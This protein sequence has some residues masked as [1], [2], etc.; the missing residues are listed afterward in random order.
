MINKHLPLF[1][2][3]ATLA[4]TGAAAQGFGPAPSGGTV[5]GPVPDASVVVVLLAAVAVLWRVVAARRAA[6]AVVV[7]AVAFFAGDVGA[8]AA[9]A[10]GLVALTTT[11]RHAAVAAVGVGALAAGMSDAVVDVVAAFDLRAAYALLGAGGITAFVDGMSLQLPHG[12]LFIAPACAAVEGTAVAFVIGAAVQT[13]LGASPRRVLALASAHAAVFAA[14]NVVRIAAIGVALTSSFA[15]AELVHALGAL[16]MIAVHVP[17]LL[18]PLAQLARRATV[19]TIAV[20]SLSSTRVAGVAAAAFVVAMPAAAAKPKEK[21]A[22][23]VFPIAGVKADDVD[24]QVVNEYVVQRGERAGFKLVLRGAPSSSNNKGAAIAALKKARAGRA[25]S[26]TLKNTGSAEE[27]RYVLETFIVSAGGK[28]IGS[29]RAE[30]SSAED[31]GAVNTAVDR[32][33]T[34]A[35]AVVDEPAVVAEAAPVAAPVV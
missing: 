22:D 24:V 14:V 13:L 3:V 5:S 31:K 34:Q 6:V 35:K 19:P 15:T 25:L 23:A 11:K 12:E 7:A 10:L 4:A 26:G 1:V 33:L 32:A 29:G 30:L 17:F 28:T 27:P 18:V 8:I 9:L 20:A 16:V 2:V 21:P